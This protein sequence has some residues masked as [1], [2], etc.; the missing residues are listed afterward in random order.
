M[1]P[2]LSIPLAMAAGA[3]ALPSVAQDLGPSSLGPSPLA[4][5]PIVVFG[6]S[7][8]F[9]DLFDSPV[10]ASVIDRTEIQ[11]RQPSSYEDLLGDIPGVSIEGGPRT[12]SQEPNIRG[13]ADEQIVIRVD[14]ARQNF[15]LAHRGRFFADPDVLKR[16]EVIRGGASTLF[17]SGALGGAILLETLDPDDVIAPGASFGGRVKGGFNSQGSEL[18]T[19]ATLAG[20][21]GRVDVLG[22]LAYRP[23]FDDLTDGNGDDIANSE[24]DAGNGLIKFGFEPSAGSR[25]EAS[26]QGYTDEG[27]VPPNANAAA[28]PTNVVD[29]SLYTQTGRLAWDYAPADSDLWDLRALVYWNEVE[30]EED[31]FVDGRADRTDLTTLGLDLSNVS[32]FNAGVPIAVTYGVELYQDDREAR[33]DGGPRL[34][35]PDAEQ[36]FAGLFAQADIELGRGVTLTPGLR[37]DWFDTDPEGGI[38]GRTD[39]QLS[40]RLAVNWRPTPNGQLYASASRSFRAPST[41]ELYNDGVHFSSPGFPLD[42]TD[43]SAPTFTG[44]NVFVPSPDLDPE[45]SL[46]FEVG[47]RWRFGDVLVPGDG[48]SVTG[49]VYFAR[50]DDYVDTVVTFIDPTTTRFDPASGRLLVDGT[51]R[52]RNV[53]A[54]LYGFEATM[55]YDATDWFAGAGL[56]IPRGNNRDGGGLG[57][58]PQDRVTLEAGFY[59]IKDMVAGLRATLRDGQD[60]AGE[61]TAGSGVLDIYATWAPTSGPLEG[62]SFLVG[63]DNVLDASYRI[64]PN[65]LSQPGRAFKLAASFAF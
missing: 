32:R 39:D 10:T 65:G 14:G 23:M 17:G 3:L 9:R 18:Q 8:D 54:D 19:S 47:G 11:T 52:S 21:S 59:P 34:Q 55:R 28:T 51:T 4:L 25:F 44:N 38:E 26:W 42:P 35:S 16:V 31:R 29:R 1:T 12:I 41:T 27:D 56:T 36:T 33:R 61:S 2:R 37:Y 22:F 45:D 62:G 58:I 15:N 6:G 48:M 49:A 13:F 50:V 24:I 5:E 46:Q 53:D 20:R 57:S 43:P 30:V 64:H 60:G 40:P 63:I 7:R